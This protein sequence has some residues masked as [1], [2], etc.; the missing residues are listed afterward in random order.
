MRRRILLWISALALILAIAAAAILLQAHAQID[1]LQPALPGPEEIRGAPADGPLPIGLSVV[2]TAQQ[3]S[4][5]SGVLDPSRDPGTAQPYVMTHAAFVLEWPDGRLF[6]IDSGLTPE[7]AASFG[8]PLEWL[9]ADPIQPLGAIGDQLAGARSRIAGV[10]FTHLHQ[11]HTSGLATL[12]TGGPDS[13]LVFQTRLQAEVGNFTTAPGN[14]DL[15]EAGCA[16]YRRLADLPLAP[17]PGFP[18]LFVIRA[19]GHT[20]GSQIF[21]A[22]VQGA[23][24][25]RTWIFT[26]DVV[27]HIAGIERDVPKPR[28]YSLLVV[29]ESEERLG[30]LRRYLRK[31]QNQEGF[32]LLVSHDLE[33]IR[34]Q[35]IPAW[36]TDASP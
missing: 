33:Q 9:G 34:S 2:H 1:A 17:I 31:L 29:P 27:N 8:A 14:S 21:V 35:Q 11:D 18:G 10:G 3:K 6:L 30:Q 36:E 28:L 15:A 20:P 4:P 7:D 13:V 5:R 26:G 19:A 12:C 16:E 25:P 23:D 32:N 22:R 24:G